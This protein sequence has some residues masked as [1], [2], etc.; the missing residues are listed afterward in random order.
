M[1]LKG[2]QEILAFDLRSKFD[3]H[4]STLLPKAVSGV[5]TLPEASN[6][7]TQIPGSDF[8]IGK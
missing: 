1:N 7:Q 4:I 2:R 3:H 6:G 8:K 5:F